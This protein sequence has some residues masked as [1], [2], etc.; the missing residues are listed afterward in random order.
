MI[1]SVPGPVA[2]NL[3]LSPYFK[4]IQRIHTFLL[5]WNNRLI[6]GVC[7]YD[8][9]FY[10]NE[11]YSDIRRLGKAVAAS[12]VIL[13]SD[14]LGQILSDFCSEFGELNM[15]LIPHVMIP[16]KFHYK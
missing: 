16:P 9:I 5:S 7:T 11:N 8:E 12:S 1:Y 15:V 3:L 6:E 2:E 10:Y 13:S 14:E 4:W